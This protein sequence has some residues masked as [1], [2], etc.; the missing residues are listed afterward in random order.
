MEWLKHNIPILAPGDGVLITW[1]FR[2]FRGQEKDWTDNTLLKDPHRCQT[3]SPSKQKPG[4][5]TP[6][7]LSIEFCG[8][9]RRLAAPTRGS[10]PARP[11]SARPCKTSAPGCGRVRRSGSS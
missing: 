3:F 4:G 7:W 8:A 10:A 9:L 11:Q 1:F 2:T 6:G 5:K